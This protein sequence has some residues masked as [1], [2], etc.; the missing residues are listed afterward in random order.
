VGLSSAIDILRNVDAEQALLGAILS[1]PS[2]YPEVGHVRPEQFFEPGFARIWRVI[3]DE[4]AA[5]R[6]VDFV[7]LSER[8]QDDPAI[9]ALGGRDY[10]FKLWNASFN[11][12]MGPHYAGLVIESW[13][14]RKVAELLARGQADITTVGERPA[15]TVVA[16]LRRALEDLEHAAADVDGFTSADEAGDALLDALHEEAVHGR[17]R[18]AMTGLRCM[19]RRL[20]GLRPGWLVIIGGRPSMGKSGLA[21]AA[22]YGAARINPQSLLLFFSLE[23]TE[24]EITERSVSAITHDMGDGIAYN[25]MG[26]K[27][28]AE[29]RE[30]IRQARGRLPRNV[31]ID[32]RSTVTVDDIRRKIWAAKRR[33][34]VAAVFIDYLQLMVRP[35]SQGRNEASVLAE[36]TSTLKR[37]AGEA[38]VCIILLSQ[39]SRGV[40]SRD[41]KRP[42]LHDLRESGAIEQDANAVLFPY[43]EAYY[44]ARAEPQ[45]ANS[46]EHRKWLT[47]LE[48]VRRRMDVIAAKVRGGAI[49][50]DQ[51]VYFQEYDHV[52]D[53]AP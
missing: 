31:L 38:G 21:R 3:A 52:E 25:T 9:T 30:R 44:I 37:I 2:R 45:D 4:V 24:R 48:N 47:N 41:D 39:L 53:C 40:E 14:R 13:S 5:S 34:P 22:C 6:A 11:P 26:P 28:T 43:R 16:E 8:F 23:M 35:P 49:G 42:Q 27:L 12:T 1:D 33:G 10:L 36:M 20:G 19:D 32:D 7:T 51:Q 15:A 29:E 50:T 46:P 18:G 17:E